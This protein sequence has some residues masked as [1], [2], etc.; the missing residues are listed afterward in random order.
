MTRPHDQM[1]RAWL[2]GALV[3]RQSSSARMGW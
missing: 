2:P 1:T 3:V